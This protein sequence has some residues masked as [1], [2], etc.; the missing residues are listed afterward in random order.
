[1]VLGFSFGGDSIPEGSG[2]LLIINLEG[3]P[4]GLSGIV[5]SAPNAESIDILSYGIVDCYDLSLQNTGVSQ[6]TIFQDSIINLEAGDKIGIFDSDAILNYGDCS[7]QRGELLV[8]VGIWDE[9]Q[10][11][12]VSIGS[13][14][15][16]NINGVQLS[17][18]VEG[19]SLVV[20]VYR[21]SNGIVYSTE[22]SWETGF[23]FFGEILQSVNDIHLFNSSLSKELF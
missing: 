21:P 10:L 23:G 3:Y 6:L 7:G 4:T 8:G 15:L 5:F 12:I 11:N 22:L 16:C 1:M 9:E 17:G 13:V 14:D 20:R 18:Y 2:E 19:H